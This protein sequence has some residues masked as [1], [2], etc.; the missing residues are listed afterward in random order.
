MLNS[1]SPLMTEANYKCKQLAIHMT[2]TMWLWYMRMN[3]SFSAQSSFGSAEYSKKNT[4]PFIFSE[5]CLIWSSE[6]WKCIDKFVCAHL[7]RIG[8]HSMLSKICIVFRKK[9]QRYSVWENHPNTNTNNIRFE[10]IAR[11]R[12]IFGWENPP[13]TN[14]NNIP[15]EKIAR[16]RIR[17]IFGLNKSHEYEYK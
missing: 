17:I 8:V 10:K 5:D 2:H 14:T 15:F 16:V 6:M 12:I 3:Y 9:S 1:P 4:R 7:S 13:Y 11:I